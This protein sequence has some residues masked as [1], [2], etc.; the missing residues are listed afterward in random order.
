MVSLRTAG[1]IRL[2]TMEADTK[3]GLL[4]GSQ[5]YINS[6]LLSFENNSLILTREGKLLADGIAGGLF[7]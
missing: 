7:F 6:G 2:D 4:K 1:G 3:A 5:K